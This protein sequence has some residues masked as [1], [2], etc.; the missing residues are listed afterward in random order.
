MTSA[1]KVTVTEDPG[2]RS[3]FI[4]KITAVSGSPYWPVSVCTCCFTSPSVGRT[5]S[6]VI[7]SPCVPLVMLTG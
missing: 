1:Q 4:M 5:L 3:P 2:S 6:I 7:G